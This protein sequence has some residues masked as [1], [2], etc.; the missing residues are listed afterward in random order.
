L[1]QHSDRAGPFNMGMDEAMLRSAAEHGV[2]TLRLYTWSGPWL[3]LGYGQRR[4]PSERIESCLA[5]G[6]GVVRRTTGGRAVLHGGDLT[7]SVAAPEGMLRPGLRN[8]YDQV[9]SSLLRAIRSL[10]AS[11]ATRVPASR[12]VRDHKNFDCFAAPAGD[13]I[14]VG[15]EKLVGSAQRRRGGAVLQ[16]GSIRIAADPLALAAA[17][18]I[19]PEVSISLA[20]LSLE[21]TEDALR[22]ALIASFAIDLEARF[23]EAE[24]TSQELVQARERE[25]MHRH[26]ALSAPTSKEV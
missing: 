8:S 10:G 23:S 11:Q 5:A 25:S 3:S 2:A 12:G 26:D 19:D 9:A 6:I 18:G 13:E 4:V 7:Y 17:A 16:H 24:P 15:A 20:Q 14:V 22:E 1:I 21:T